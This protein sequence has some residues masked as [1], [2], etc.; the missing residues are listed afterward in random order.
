[1]EARNRLLAAACAVS[2]AFAAPSFAERARR[3]VPATKNIASVT[4]ALRATA[5][6]G[7]SVTYTVTL[8]RGRTFDGTGDGLGV[9][10]TGNITLVSTTRISSREFEARFTSV[11]NGQAGTAL[12]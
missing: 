2:L 7:A 5:R 11:D 9:T 3:V 12:I 10:T 6:I 4:P 8:K 1:M